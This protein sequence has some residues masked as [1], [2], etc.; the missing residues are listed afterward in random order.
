M[1]AVSGLKNFYYLPHFHDMRCCYSLIMK[2]IRM[3]YHHNP[4]N[5][6]VFFFMSKN[7]RSLRMVMYEKHSFQ[8]FIL[9]LFREVYW[10]MKIL[11]E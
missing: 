3:S 5:G 8:Y 2:A 11:I 4:Y 9:V 1:L 7:E 10:F 6:D